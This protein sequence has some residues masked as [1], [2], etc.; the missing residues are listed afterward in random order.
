MDDLSIGEF[1][2]IAA[3]SKL[4]IVAE[5][6]VL[7]RVEEID[8]KKHEVD[9]LE[10]CFTHYLQC[11]TESVFVSG[12]RSSDHFVTEMRKKLKRLCDEAIEGIKV[13]QDYRGG[14]CAY[15]KC[16][17][18]AVAQNVAQQINKTSWGWKAQQ[19]IASETK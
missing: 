3:H 19:C 1:S 18:E 4:T 5:S 12:V 6:K 7:R 11:G 9:S 13:F 17:S 16:A 10:D 2:R 14:R 8:P 15:L